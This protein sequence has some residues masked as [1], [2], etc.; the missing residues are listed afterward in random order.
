MPEV[1]ELDAMK[2]IDVALSGIADP[3][4]RARI[5]KWAWDKFSNTPSS[6]LLGVEPPVDKRKSMKTVRKTSSKGTTKGKTSHTLLKSLDLAPSGKKSFKD[7]VA[8]TQ[9]TSNPEKCVVAVYYVAKILEKPSV[10]TDHV[11]TCFKLQTWRVPANLDN[12]LQW[13]A[14]QKAWLDTA[15]MSNIKITTH[16]ENL[17]EHDLPRTK[18]MGTK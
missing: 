15:S 11:F 3:P 8:E 18:K 17:I 16:G 5:L 4:T 9:P 7:F 6:G 13:V 2:S 1:S 10:G 12:T 14:S